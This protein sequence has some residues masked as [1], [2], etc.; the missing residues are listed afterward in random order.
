ME[1]E[2][3]KSEVID[4]IFKDKTTDRKN[5]ITG[6]Q[7]N[8]VNIENKK[9]ENIQNN[10]NDL[11]PINASNKDRFEKRRQ[12]LWLNKINL[13]QKE[14]EKEETPSPIIQE[15]IKE[16]VKVKRKRDKIIKAYNFLTEFV[17]SQIGCFIMLIIIL[18]ILC[19]YDL[20]MIV[21]SNKYKYLYYGCYVIFLFYSS[22]DFVIRTIIIENLIKSLY[23]WIDLLSLVIIIFDFDSLSY[24]L[25][26]KIL[27]CHH[28]KS[29]Y[30]SYHDQ[31]RI[32][33]LLNV[34]QIVK[35]FRV[36][37][38]YK[39]FVDLIKEKEKKSNIMKILE[40]INEKKNKTN[41]NKLIKHI[42]ATFVQMKEFNNTTTMP[43]AVTP[44]NHGFE[45]KTPNL[46]KINERTSIITSS[47]SQ[48]NRKW[49]EDAIKYLEEH[50]FKKNKISQKITEGI[51]RLMIVI[52]L[53]VFI[54]SIFTDED[55]YGSDYFSYKIICKLINRFVK[56][57]KMLNEND[58]SRFVKNYLLTN[59]LILYPIIQVEWNEKIVYQ[60]KSMNLYLNEYMRRD[61]CY[62]FDINDPSTVII[63]SRR[64]MSKMSS[65]IYLCR[66]FYKGNF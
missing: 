50:I 45:P 66:L 41:K 6:T 34:F 20:K 27:N 65:V 42:R 33:I 60:N 56:D 35:L 12:G 53:L 61:I 17:S 59:K 31:G 57:K 29:K 8:N 63:I 51:S 9:N 49:E 26:H 46:K 2:I 18:F 30:I 7:K 11:S 62:I 22:I 39:L 40:K 37:K 24:P 25:L 15:E 38:F 16:E 48:D 21:F 4:K 43:L 1:I 36:V 23:F 44:V 19:Y 5:L 52:V 13:M 10:D 54:V 58:V 14:N 55:N 28:P 47:L 32:E 3:P 64:V